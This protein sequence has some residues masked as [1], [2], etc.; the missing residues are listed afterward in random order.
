M[1]CSH[2]QWILEETLGLI[3]RSL[4]RQG[5][6]EERG[7]GTSLTLMASLIARTPL[8]SF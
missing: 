8:I 7:R 6:G 3:L 1:L 5:W 2:Q 4:K